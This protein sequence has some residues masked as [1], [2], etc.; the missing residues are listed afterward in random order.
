M[1]RSGL[2]RPPEA[3]KPL[4]HLTGAVNILPAFC[5]SA[6]SPFKYLPNEMFT[7]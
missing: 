4:E 3:G 2:G 6:S 5:L 7:P 1:K